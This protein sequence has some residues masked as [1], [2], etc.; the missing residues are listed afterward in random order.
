MNAEQN[1][2]VCVYI[3]AANRGW[4]GGGWFSPTISQFRRGCSG[5]NPMK[6]LCVA[7]TYETASP[8]E[9]VICRKTSSQSIT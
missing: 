3:G 5:T 2:F 6:S 1:V 8:L 9:S 7:G 4:G